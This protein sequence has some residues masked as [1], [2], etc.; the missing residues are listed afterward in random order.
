MNCGWG[1]PGHPNLSWKHRSSRSPEKRSAP[2]KRGMFPFLTLYV[3][4][5]RGGK[6]QSLPLCGP[7]HP[8]ESDNSV[9]YSLRRW[10]KRAT[11]SGV[12]RADGPVTPMLQ[13]A[14]S[15]PLTTGPDSDVNPPLYSSKLQ[16]YPLFLTLRI[17][18][19]NALGSRIV[20]GVRGR[21]SDRISS[22]SCSG[23][24]ASRALAPAPAHKCIPSRRQE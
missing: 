3:P 5:L 24:K 4:S 13:R 19:L 11:I 1:G 7:G 18:S 6:T 15:L 21:A 2:I 17:S 14:S 10:P 23:R 16:A 22:L 12:K 9:Q 8:K 20:C